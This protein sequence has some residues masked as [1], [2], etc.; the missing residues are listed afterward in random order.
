[1]DLKLLLECRRHLRVAHHVPGRI[2]L[3]FTTE[4]FRHSALREAIAPFLKGAGLPFDFERPGWL[5]NNAELKVAGAVPGI[6]SARLN[7]RGRSLIVQYDD[8]LLP[9]HKIDA[10]FAADTP[11]RL[12]GVVADLGTRLTDGTN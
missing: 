5:K 8:R 4:L 6:R 7:W 12:G 11:E 10:L 9:A 1:M 3:K 2:R